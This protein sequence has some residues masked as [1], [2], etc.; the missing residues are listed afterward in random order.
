MNLRN[1]N[2]VLHSTSANQVYIGLTSLGTG[3]MYLMEW[4]PGSDDL[5]HVKMINDQNAGYN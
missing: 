3:N 1:T 4:E 2:S 5:S